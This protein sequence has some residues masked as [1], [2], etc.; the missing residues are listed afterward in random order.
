M[1]ASRYGVAQILSVNTSKVVRWIVAATQR[2]TAKM[3]VGVEHSAGTDGVADSVAKGV[4]H[5]EVDDKITEIAR[6]SVA[7]I[8][9][10]NTCKVV[11]RVIGATHWHAAQMAVGVE[12]GAGTDGVADSV[13]NGVG[14][15][16]IN[17][18]IVETSCSRI[19]QI[20]C[21]NAL[22]VVRRIIG[23]AHGCQTQMSVGIYTLASTNGASEGVAEGVVD[24]QIYDKVLKAAI[25]RVAQ[26]LG[27][28]SR[29]IVWWVVVTA[30]GG[31]AQMAVSVDNLSGTDGAVD[32]VAKGV[33]NGQIDIQHTVAST[34]GKQ[35][36]IVHSGTRQSVAILDKGITRTYFGCNVAI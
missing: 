28:N 17:N 3:S 9:S 29:L 7:E 25:E 13:A 21:V 2:D 5:G 19:T 36:L 30:H 16:D 31:A 24:N 20:L 8:L 10:V 4:V 23:P 33:A 32:C 34:N 14:Y 27:K 22:I 26:I 35:R 12:H 18:K 1:I 11:R 6:Y 15:N